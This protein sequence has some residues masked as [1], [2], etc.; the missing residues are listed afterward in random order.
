MADIRTIVF[1]VDFSARSAGAAHYVEALARDLNPKI[2]MIHVLPPAHYE[3]MSLE[4]TGPALAEV[5]ASREAAA[6]AQMEKFLTPE[7]DD[8]D[9]ERA[10]LDGDPGRKIVDFAES[11]NADLIAMPTHGY[12][13]FRRFI[14]GSVT[15]KVLHDAKCP[16]LTGVHME[17]A[18][19]LDR[20]HFRTIVVALDLCGSS[21]YILQ[22]AGQLAQRYQAKLVLTHVVPSIEGKAGEYFDP[23]WR[24]TFAK[25]ARDKIGCLLSDLGLEAEVVIGWGEAS[26]QVCEVAVAH[27]ADLLIIGRGHTES[28][29]G[30]LRTHSYAIIRMAACP[31]ISV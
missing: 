21:R 5:L 31:V 6:A 22:W 30:R 23:E 24:D 15:A 28:A 29:L 20:I 4:V 27:Q 3:A 18:P 8:F 14:L 25:P 12:G 19:P 16:V 17:Q 13:P 7:L 11:V 9:V 2:H 26:K 10:V 1:P